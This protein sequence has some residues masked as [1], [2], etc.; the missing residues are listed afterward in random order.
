MTHV[1]KTADKGKRRPGQHGQL[2][3][4]NSPWM[5]NGMVFPWI[6]LFSHG[7]DRKKRPSEPRRKNKSLNSKRTSTVRSDVEHQGPHVQS[8]EDVFSKQV[9]AET[10]CLQSRINE[11]FILYSSHSSSYWAD[12]RAD[13]LFNSQVNL[14]GLWRRICQEEVP[15]AG[16]S[17]LRISMCFP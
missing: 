13:F 8:S 1:L 17:L 3:F 10:G 7:G 2:R 5:A 6:L 4:E 11:V 15:L 14:P 9:I 16:S 12:A